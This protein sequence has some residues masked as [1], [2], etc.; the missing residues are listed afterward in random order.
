MM[1]GLSYYFGLMNEKISQRRELFSGFREFRNNW[2]WFNIFGSLFGFDYFQSRN[3]MT[4]DD[5]INFTNSLPEI[6]ISNFEV[7]YNSLGMV[8]IPKKNLEYAIAR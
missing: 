4:F 8:L 6:L 7:L 1:F 3:P 5:K 2:D